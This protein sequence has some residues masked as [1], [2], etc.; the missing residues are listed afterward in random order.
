MPSI[1]RFTFLECLYPMLDDTTLNPSPD[2]FSGNLNLSHKSHF[3]AYP[4]AVFFFFLYV[5]IVSIM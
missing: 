3:Q 2:E 4:V 1:L 5:E